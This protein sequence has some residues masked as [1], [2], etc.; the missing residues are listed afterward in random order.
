[1]IGSHTA[2]CR[3]VWPSTHARFEMALPMGK[4]PEQLISTVARKGATLEARRP[5]QTSRVGTPANQHR[6]SG[7]VMRITLAVVFRDNATMMAVMLS[8]FPAWF[9]LDGVSETYIASGTSSC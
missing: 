1:M 9:M 7:Q 6:V 2:E 3:I 8:L 4:A 5:G